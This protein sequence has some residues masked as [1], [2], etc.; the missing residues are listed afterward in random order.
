MD[1]N[2]EREKLKMPEYG[3]YINSYVEALKKM[4][5]REERTKAAHALVSVMAQLNAGLR[6]TSDYKHKLWDHLVII[7]DYD[8]DVDNPYPMPDRTMFSVHP[9]HIGYN[10]N[11]IQK[12][13]Y[14]KIVER[15]VSKIP[16]YNGEERE[17]LITLVANAMKRNYLNW[18]KNAVSDTTIINDLRQL[19]PENVEVSNTIKLSEP[20]ELISKT[21]QTQK[22]NN[23][24]QKNKHRNRK[25]KK[26]K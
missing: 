22:Q 24:S 1:Y 5:T 12:R 14:G 13:H 7:A 20:N 15:I 4:P 21:Q 26:A 17:I 9:S 16:E 10:D 23:K 2:T 6:N 18:N 25:N 19:L 3:R 8:L 11:N